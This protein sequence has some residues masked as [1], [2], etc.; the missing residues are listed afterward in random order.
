MRKRLE[1]EMM[2]L[3]YRAHRGEFEQLLQL[4]GLNEGQIRI[5]RMERYQV[6]H[7]LSSKAVKAFNST[8]NDSDRK[9][10]SKLRRRLSTGFCEICGI[11]MTGAIPRQRNLWHLETL[12][13]L[14]DHDLGGAV[15]EEQVSVLCRACNMTLGEM[16]SDISRRTDGM[17]D[18]DRGKIVYDF[19]LFKHVIHIGHVAA[20]R[21]FKEEFLKFWYIRRGRANKCHRASLESLSKQELKSVQSTVYW[22]KDCFGH[23]HCQ[24]CGACHSTQLSHATG[25]NLPNLVN[26]I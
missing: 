13:H 1:R 2:D 16:K 15:K 7:K 21:D 14:L 10:T 8:R 23:H 24:V 19:F 11:T 18:D 17:H 4:R 22:T 6:F 20:A 9:S 5:A 26:P 12:E 3:G 25:H